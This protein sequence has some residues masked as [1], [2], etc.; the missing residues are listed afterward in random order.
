VCVCVCVCV[1][2][3]SERRRGN[4]HTPSTLP[5]FVL[6]VFS[7]FLFCP[8]F[9]VT[10]VSLSTTTIPS[11]VWELM[12]DPVINFFATTFT[13]GVPDIPVDHHI[14]IARSTSSSSA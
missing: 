3:L 12:E 7:F 6:S 1:S 5:C 11:A 2:E 10:Y 13:F 9:F 8:F 4:L 14:K